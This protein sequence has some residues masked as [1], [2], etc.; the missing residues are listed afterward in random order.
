MLS[1]LLHMFRD[2]LQRCVLPIEWYQMRYL[3]HKIFIKH[4]RFSCALIT[5]QFS[6]KTVL[7]FNENKFNVDNKQNDLIIMNLL[8]C[9]N[10]KNKFIP[11]IWLE[12]ILTAVAIIKS[13][14]TVNYL[15]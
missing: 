15:V 6:Y 10:W 8:L 2:L 14:M 3:Q 11:K 4:L 12:C 5:Q 9:D 1:E 13:L 7:S